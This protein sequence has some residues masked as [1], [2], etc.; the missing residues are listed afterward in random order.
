MEGCLKVDYI[1]AYNK[2]P[3][4]CLGQKSLRCLKMDYIKA[5]NKIPLACL[6]K[7]ICGACKW[8]WSK[9]RKVGSAPP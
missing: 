7:G 8:T 2:I 9:L 6:D 4:A 5:Y 1:K 3:L